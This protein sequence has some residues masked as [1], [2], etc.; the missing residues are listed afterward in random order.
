MEGWV[1]KTTGKRFSR[2]LK[3]L[4]RLQNLFP[5]GTGQFRGV[6]AHEGDR[7]HSCMYESLA[8]READWA[9]WGRAYRSA[10]GEGCTAS[11]VES[12]EPIACRSGSNP[13][14]QHW[15]TPHHT[16]SC[17]Q[18]PVLR[19]QEQAKHQ[20]S[21]TT[22]SSTTSQFCGTKAAGSGDSLSWDPCLVLIMCLSCNNIHSSVYF[23][24]L[25]IV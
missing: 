1:R 4:F 15:Q 13:S 8:P 18:K 7:K 20:A 23:L 24:H 17:L 5:E 22:Q 25:H 6:A 19:S 21:H 9:P 12:R 11:P 14:P 3:L 10:G 2:N 16:T